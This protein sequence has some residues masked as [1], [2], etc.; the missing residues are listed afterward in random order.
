MTT[1]A[2]LR[3][4]DELEGVDSFAALGA[5]IDE[6]GTAATVVLGRLRIGG[7]VLD[8]FAVAGALGSGPTPRRLGVATPVG[9][10][11]AASIIAREATAASL[12]GG[13]EVLLLEG[14]PASCVDAARVVAALFTPGRHT[15]STA[16]ASITEAVNDPL[17]SG[18]LMVC[19]RDGPALVSLVGGAVAEV[20]EVRETAAMPPA[21]EAVAGRLC[22]PSGWAP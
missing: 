12:L 2:L 13:C 16:T 20:G 8:E 9:A 6:L 17:P 18:E 7:V 15:L 19:W 3:L 4:P 11:R 21:P 1:P 5:A 14:A 22:V 10:G